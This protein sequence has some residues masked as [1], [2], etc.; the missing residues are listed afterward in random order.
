MKKFERELKELIDGE[1]FRLAKKFSPAPPR[2]ADVRRLRRAAQL[3]CRRA[4]GGQDHENFISNDRV[5]AFQPTLIVRVV[6]AAASKRNIAPARAFV[7]IAIVFGKAYAPTVTYLAAIRLAL[8][9]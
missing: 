8:R 3:H 7:A 9:F 5:I 4:D 1:R 2:A 6:P